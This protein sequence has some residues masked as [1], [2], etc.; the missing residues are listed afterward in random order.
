MFSSAWHGETLVCLASLADGQQVFLAIG[1]QA[2]DVAL[3]PLLGIKILPPTAAMPHALHALYSTDAPVLERFFRA[4]APNKGPRAL[5]P[6]QRLGIGTRMTTAVWP[7][8]WAAMTQA[9]F[10]ANAIQNSVRDLNFLETLLEARPV[11]KNIAFGFGAIETGYTGS[12]YEGLWV[13]GVL[14]ALKHCAQ[15]PYGA[16]ADHI[17]VKRGGDGLARAKWLLDATRYYSFHTLDVSDVLDYGALLAAGGVSLAARIPD[18]ARRRNLLAYRRQLRRIGGF[19]YRPDDETLARLVGKYWV[20]LDAVVAMHEHTSGFKAGTPFDL[21]LSIDEHPNEEPTFDCLTSET[22]L[23]FVLMEAQRRGIPLTRVAPNFGVEKRTDYRGADGLPGFEARARTLCRIAAELGVMADFHSGD[24]LSAAARQ[25][26][27][28]ATVGRNHFKVSPNLSCCSLRCWPLTIPT[29]SGAGVRMRWPTR[30][31]KQRQGQPS[32][33]VVSG[34]LTLASR[35]PTTRCSTTS[36]LRS[37]GGGTRTGN[38]SAARSSAAS[39]RPFTR[40]ARSALPHICL[41]WRTIASGG[42]SGW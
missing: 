16:D 31:A 7:A 25:A 3:G 23:I 9:G 26:I 34:N 41:C 12:I 24:D 18:P 13:A 2:P 17:Q 38:S 29:C 33:S 6:V 8:I 1:P 5:G 32:P 42:T 28:R 21:E 20:A 14:D 15:L 39:R 37:S 27:G 35:H 22:E 19:D 30:S 36:A 10:A 11:E 4:L 40:P